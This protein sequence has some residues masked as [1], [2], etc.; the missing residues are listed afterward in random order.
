MTAV[1][2]SA[3]V[4][5]NC[6]FVDVAVHNCLVFFFLS[7]LCVSLS[8]VVTTF[9]KCIMFCSN[10]SAIIMLI[11]GLNYELQSARSMFQDQLEP[12]QV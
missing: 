7:S 2:G 12:N 3:V 5:V 6:S 11:V 10:D 8:S 4:V 1:F 9:F